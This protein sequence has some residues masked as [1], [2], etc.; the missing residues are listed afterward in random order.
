MARDT[1]EKREAL[2]TRL[3]DIAERRIAEGGLASLKARDLAQEAPCSVGAIYTVF[4]DL[5]AIAL[6]VNGRTFKRIGETVG[7]ASHQKG[8]PPE[9]TLVALST[10]YL[11]FATENPALWRAL[12]DIEL[13]EQDEVPDWYLAELKQLFGFIAAPL[14]Q[15]YPEYSEADIALMTRAL[16]SSVHGIVLLGLERRISGVPLEELERMIELVLTNIATR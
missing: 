1:T 16:F 12:F 2:R 6:A 10:A 13:T 8:L 14:A 7:A 11:H 4:G 3:I 5:K 9:E 15:V